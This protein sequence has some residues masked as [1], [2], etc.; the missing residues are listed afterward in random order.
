MV[1]EIQNPRGKVEVTR[2]LNIE[3][4]VD[5]PLDYLLD[6]SQANSKTL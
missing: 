3:S 4:K 6:T 5:S 2:L 1:G